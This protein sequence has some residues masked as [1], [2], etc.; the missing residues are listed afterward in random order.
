MQTSAFR[1]LYVPVFGNT[2]H[3]ATPGLENFTATAGFGEVKFAA[4]GLRGVPHSFIRC[5]VAISPHGRYSP[6]VAIPPTPQD[7]Y[8]T[9]NEDQPISFFVVI[10]DTDPDG[11]V[12]PTTIALA[13]SPAHG[14]A[15]VDDLNGTV[16]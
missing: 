7:D 9:T 4:P 8:A 1:V 12:I 10:N 16:I 14:L 3:A 2:G 13:G 11:T 15:L 5:A 6:A